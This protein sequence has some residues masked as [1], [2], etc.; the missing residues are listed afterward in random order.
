MQIGAESAHLLCEAPRLL[1]PMG[2]SGDC[3][4][5]VTAE[6]PFRG[7]HPP[8]GA[9]AEALGRGARSSRIRR[10]SRGRPYLESDED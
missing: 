10:G 6:E 7:M 5:D 2:G 1:K 8:F 4:V 9:V 3:C